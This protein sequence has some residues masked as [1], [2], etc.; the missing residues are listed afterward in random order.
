[1]RQDIERP[2]PKYVAIDDGQFLV[3]SS[4]LVNYDP[5]LTYRV[6]EFG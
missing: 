6:N 3:H 2:V 1:M 5:D 4:S